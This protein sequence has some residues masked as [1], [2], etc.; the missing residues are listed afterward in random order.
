MNRDIYEEAV[1]CT[2]GIA[3]N[4]EFS[5]PDRYQSLGINSNVE[6]IVHNALVFVARDGTYP[7]TEQKALDAIGAA[8]ERELRKRASIAQLHFE[9]A[10]AADKE[11]HYMRERL[12]DQARVLEMERANRRTAERVNGQIND[13]LTDVL[14]LFVPEDHDWPV[15][16]TAA[17]YI[18][19]AM[20][21]GKA[22]KSSGVVERC[23]T[24]LA[25]RAKQ[26]EGPELAVVQGD[27]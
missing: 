5:A 19:E 25:E 14:G 1:R 15:R 6:D 8:A 9:R 23:E 22:W 21:S 20:V 2:Q 12:E 18:A 7:T 3:I 24:Y 10:A 11:I 16:D 17:S 13:N 27:E 26:Q 4:A